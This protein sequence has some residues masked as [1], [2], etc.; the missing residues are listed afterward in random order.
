MVY[1]LI[2]DPLTDR[3]W[4]TISEALNPIYPLVRAS[5]LLY[6]P[7]SPK[8]PTHLA[9][10]IAFGHTIWWAQV[11]L[12]FVRMLSWECR[13]HINLWCIFFFLFMSRA[14]VTDSSPH[15]GHYMKCKNKK[16]KKIEKKEEELSKSF[17]GSRMPTFLKGSG[18]SCWGRRKEVKCSEA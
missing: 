7:P 17:G 9:R 2:P 14:P 6:R 16:T 15:R 3:T 5:W 1:G 4:D 18:R 11:T 13:L 10:L 12:A 8:T